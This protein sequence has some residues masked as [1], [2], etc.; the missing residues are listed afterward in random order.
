MPIVS[1]SAVS[2]IRA[3]T[4]MWTR[5]N[6]FSR[7]VA[8]GVGAAIALGVLAF[9][10]APFV[11]AVGVYIAPFGLLVPILDRIPLPLINEVDRLLPIAGPAAGVGLIL[12]A[13]L[14]F[15]S[16]IFVVLYFAWVSVRRKRNAKRAIANS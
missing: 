7:S 16:V 1:S 11:D 4:E 14:S 2:S 10:L 6:T 9:A 13:V 15:W 5:M 3:K 12:V 8:V